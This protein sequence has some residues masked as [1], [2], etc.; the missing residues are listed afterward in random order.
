MLCRDLMPRSCRRWSCRWPARCRLPVPC[1]RTADPMPATTA[2]RR[3]VPCRPSPGSPTLALAVVSTCLDK[4][5]DCSIAIIICYIAIITVLQIH[6]CPQLY[7]PCVV[8]SVR[9]VCMRR[10]SACADSSFLHSSEECLFTIQ[11]M[12]TG[13]GCTHTSAP[14]PP[15]PPPSS[16]VCLSGFYGSG[17]V[18]HLKLAILP[19]ECHL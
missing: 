15:P 2:R 8:L 16:C 9:T 6:G 3:R 5:H 18:N 4:L 19:L 11:L 13:S 12:I 1:P 14:P 7:N 17:C 10:W